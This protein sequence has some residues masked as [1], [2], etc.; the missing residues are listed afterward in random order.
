MGLSLASATVVTGPAIAAG[1]A[2]CPGPDD[3]IHDKDKNKA[4]LEKDKD[5]K[6]DVE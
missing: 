3:P 5:S 4:K 2:T 1:P 6:K